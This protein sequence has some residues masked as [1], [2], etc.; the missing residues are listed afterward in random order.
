MPQDRAGMVGVGEEGEV[1][2]VW[3]Q[4]P[5]PIVLL[6]P[7][8]I[9][10]ASACLLKGSKAVRVKVTRGGTAELELSIAKRCLCSLVPVGSPIQLVSNFPR[11]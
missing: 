4:S 11:F 10:S 5:Q 3:K 2:E 6:P 7:A 8:G 9:A 1:A